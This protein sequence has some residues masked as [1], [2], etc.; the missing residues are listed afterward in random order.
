MIFF[1]AVF[2]LGSSLV[3]WTPENEGEVTYPEEYTHRPLLEWF[4]GLGCPPCINGAHP[5]MEDVME[6][7]DN[8]SGEPFHM[9]VFHNNLS[10]S[11]RDDLT[12]EKSL[13][14]FDYY[15]DDLTGEGIPNMIF[16]GGFNELNPQDP[17]AIWEEINAAGERSV[18]KATL[19][20]RFEL[21][22][23]RLKFYVKANNIDNSQ[24]QGSLYVFI[25]ENDVLAYSS[26][27]DDNITSELV[28]RDYG[29]EGRSIGI[30]VG[31]WFNTS[32]EWIIDLNATVPINPEKLSVVAA[33]YDRADLAS[34]KLP[35]SLDPSNHYKKPTPRCIQSATPESTEHDGGF[36]LD[37]S[38]ITF[39]SIS[40][41]PL[42]PTPD[43]EVTVSATIV[44]TYPLV[45]ATLDYSVGETDY[46][47]FEMTKSGDNYTAMIG[48]FNAGDNVVYKLSAEDEKGV[49]VASSDKTFEVKEKPAD[50]DDDD[51][52][53]DDISDDDNGDD[54]DD[55]PD[56]SL[57]ISNVRM[58][59]EVPYQGADV[60]I[61][62]TVESDHKIDSVEVSYWEEGDN[63][64]FKDMRK[65]GGEYYATLGRFDDGVK[66]FYQITATDDSGNEETG[67][68]LSISIGSEGGDTEPVDEDT[69]GFGIMEVL[70]VLV[71][72]VI[73]MV[74][75]R[76]R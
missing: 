35:P 2:L 69:P 68:E 37:P 34:A 64:S 57:A 70:V 8:I 24:I 19:W 6:E 20:V 65:S 75:M 66:L 71:V 7:H 54:D 44:S 41:T 27:A 18:K 46:P 63:P 23:D 58:D 51:D 1:L 55:E 73:A 67:E 36:P 9:V 15:K 33:I 43:D 48:P 25:I 74:Y 22:G 53:D 17:E 61:Y 3:L 12:T 60:R 32:E 45:S 50:D 38:M 11:Q 4:T 16:D 26:V 21:R 62:A 28:F 42:E 56:G 30:D 5:A 29:I 40:H 72:L 47:L 76:R 13:D 49:A 52:D 39:N 14:R 31:G 10:G 59:P